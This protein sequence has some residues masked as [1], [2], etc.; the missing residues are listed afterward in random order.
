[1]MGGF[2]EERDDDG[3]TKSHFGMHHH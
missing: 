2:R 1:V 3:E